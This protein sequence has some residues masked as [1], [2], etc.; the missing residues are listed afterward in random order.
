MWIYRQS[1]GIFMQN[2][3]GGIWYKGYAGHPPYV[4]DPYSQDLIAQGPLPRW[5]YTMKAA[6]THPTLGPVAIEL[7]PQDD[8]FGR[9]LGRSRFWIHP[10]NPEHPGKSSD[11]CIV[12]PHDARVAIDAQTDR[13]LEVTW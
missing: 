8:P 1:T 9:M 4:N 2:K 12:L 11:G 3:P 13:D 5:F 7:V 6:I 10:D